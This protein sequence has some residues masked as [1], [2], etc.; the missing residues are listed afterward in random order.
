MISL[1]D[2]VLLPV[3]EYVHPMNKKERCKDSRYDVGSHEFCSVSDV[4]LTSDG[5]IEYE[6][7]NSI[8][9]FG[10]VQRL[11]NVWNA[12]GALLHSC[13]GCSIVDLSTLPSGLLLLQTPGGLLRVMNC[14]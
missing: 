10:R 4:S 11:V 7:R 12:G 1:R 3:W 6:L 9:C 2:N 8:L 14:R 5:N 13:T